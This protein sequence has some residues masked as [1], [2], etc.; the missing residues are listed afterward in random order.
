MGSSQGYFC[1]H[2]PICF[3]F[4]SLEGLIRAKNNVIR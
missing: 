2:E 3:E 4:N 1:G